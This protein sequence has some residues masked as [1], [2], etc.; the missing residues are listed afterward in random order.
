MSTGLSVH[1]S[2]Y[3]LLSLSISPNHLSILQLHNCYFFVVLSVCSLIQL[4]SHSY[5]HPSVTTF[6]YLFVYTNVSPS[7]H[8]SMHMSISLSVH[9]SVHLSLCL[10]ISEHAS[11]LLST[12]R[13]FACPSVCVSICPSNHQS[14]CPPVC[15]AISSSFL[16]SVHL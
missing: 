7:I 8:P 1:P 4:P 6:I 12:H 2:N 11:I 13:F 3:L 15:L 16:M 10:S 5:V 9:L 14:L